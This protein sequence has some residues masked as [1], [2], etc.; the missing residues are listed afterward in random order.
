MQREQSPLEG[1]WLELLFQP[2]LLPIYTALVVG[3]VLVW[4][5]TTPVRNVCWALTASV[6]AVCWMHFELAL[7]IAEGYVS[8]AKDEQMRALRSGEYVWTLYEALFTVPMAVIDNDREKYGAYGSLAFKGWDFL[9]EFWCVYLPDTTQMLVDSSCLYALGWLRA[10]VASYHRA[11]G[12]VCGLF[13]A[14]MLLLAVCVYVPLTVLRV[15]EVLFRGW[16]G[17]VVV[18]VF[19][20][21]AGWFY[22][23]GQWVVYI[24]A[25]GVILMVA[26]LVIKEPRVG[27]ELDKISP[28]YVAQWGWKQVVTDA[29]D[30]RE[31]EQR[32]LSVLTGVPEHPQDLERQD[33]SAHESIAS[34]GRSPS[35]IQAEIRQQR[36]RMAVLE[37]EYKETV[38]VRRGRLNSSRGGC[39][40]PRCGDG[41]DASSTARRAFVA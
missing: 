35:A 41:E 1:S 32:E 33:K 36:Q 4:V 21:A 9:R 22:E 18:L 8:L 13:W 20:N 5:V 17:V 15:L 25:V 10:C 24:T 29:H 12:V 37:R 19:V 23:W 30:R 16:K 31:K 28:K 38:K 34:E 14:V 26:Q 6:A 2:A 40:A 27:E 39:P 3:T 11:E 7:K